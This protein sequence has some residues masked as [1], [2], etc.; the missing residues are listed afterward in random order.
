MDTGS[1]IRKKLF[2]SLGFVILVCVIQLYS[3]TT[4][5]FR[6]G[7]TGDPKPEEPQ[8]SD[9]IDPDFNTAGALGY[10]MLPTAGSSLV[11]VSESFAGVYTVYGEA[12]RYLSW[13]LKA[14]LIG[15]TTT[16]TVHTS[17]YQSA[18]KRLASAARCCV[19]VWKNDDSGKR[20]NTFIISPVSTAKKSFSGW[21]SEDIIT[22]VAGNAVQVEDGDRLV[23]EFEWDFSS[24]KTSAFT[25]KYGFNAAADPGYGYITCVN[26][27]LHFMPYIYSISPSS[28]TVN[29]T[30]S[31]KG[32]YFGDSPSA[33]DGIQLSNKWIDYDDPEVVN[34][35]DSEIVVTVP[36]G[37]VSGNVYVTRGGQNS[38]N[39]YFWILPTVSAASPNEAGQRASLWVTV[40]GKSFVYGCTASF[41]AGITVSSTS[42]VS[43]TEIKVQISISAVAAEG[44]R[45]ITVTNPDGTTNTL[46]DGFTVKYAPAVTSISPTERG[47]NAQNQDIVIN[48][49]YIMSG[50]TVYFM[51]G[52]NP[53]PDITINSYDYSGCGYFSGAILVVN[54]TVGPNADTL[55]NRAIKI[56]NPDLGWVQTDPA[57]IGLKINPKPT[58]ISINTGG[59]PSNALGQNASNITVSISGSNFQDTP[60]VQ[61]IPADGIGI[62]SVNFIDAGNIEIVVSV[63]SSAPTTWRDVKVIN[64]DQGNITQSSWFKINVKPTIYG[65]KDPSPPSRG[66]GCVNQIIVISGLNFSGSQVSFEGTGINV[67]W[68]NVDNSS[69]V[70]CQIDISSS[71]AT[72]WRYIKVTNQDFGYDTLLSAFEVTPA[73]KV[74]FIPSPYDVRGQGATNQNIPVRGSNF[75][76]G[77]TLEFIGGGFTINSYDY[78]SIPSTITVNV[79]ISLGAATGLRAIRATNPDA[80]TYVTHDVITVSTAPEVSSLSPNV[81]GQGASN[82]TIV[83]SGNYFQ[84]GCQVQF[85]QDPSGSPVDTT[86]TINNVTFNSPS[87][88]NI[89]ITIDPNAP[90]GGRYMKIVNPDEGNKVSANT[91]LNITNRPSFT[92]MSPDNRGQ[93]CVNEW[94]NVLGNYFQYGCNAWFSNPDITVSSTSYQAMD[95]IKIQISISSYAATGPCDLIVENPDKGISTFSGVF[96]VNK[97]PTV[98]GTIPNNLGQ[99]AVDQVVTITG[100]DFQSGCIADFG[101]GITVDWTSFISTTQIQAQIDIDPDAGT[102]ARNITVYNPDAGKHTG[103]GVFTVNPKPIINIV[104]P[105]KVGQGA[106]GWEITL[107]GANFDPNIQASDITISGGGVT[108]TTVTYVS[109]DKTQLKFKINVEATASTTTLRSI[110]VINPD[111]GRYTKENCFQITLKPVINSCSPNKVGQGA[112][113]VNINISGD[114]FQN[115]STVSFSQDSTGSPEDTTI[116]INNVTY[117]DPTSLT[118]NVT[119][120]STAPAGGRYITV[121]N[122]DGGRTTSATTL[123]TVS[124]R[125]NILNLSPNALGQG[126]SNIDVT[127]NGSNFQ[128]GCSVSFSPS[129]GIFIN[130]VNFVDALTVVVNLSVDATASTGTRSC[131]LTNPDYGSDTLNNALTINHKPVLDASPC[132]PNTRGA[133]AQSQDITITGQYFVAT[134]Q[135]EFSGGGITVNFVNFTDSTTIVA[136]IDIS[137][138]AALTTRNV[139]VT[140]PD[141]GWDT[142]YNVF[143]VAGNPVVTNATPDSR[144]QGAENQDILIQGNNF[145]E[146]CTVEFSNAG[147]TVNSVYRHGVSSLT[148]NISISPTAATG[149]CDITVINEDAGQGTGDDIFTINPKPGISGL[150]PDE[151]GQGAENM[152]ILINGSNFVNAPG[153]NV[154]FSTPGINVNSVEYMTDTQLRIFVTIST[155]VVSGVAYDVTV[156]NPDG[157]KNTL[158]NAFTV[159]P[160]PV[161]SATNPNNA[162]QGATDIQVFVTGSNFVY[163]ADVQFSGTGITVSS[164]AYQD[165]FTIKCT[166]S[167]SE[168]ATTGSRDVTVINPDNGKC[169]LVGGFTVNPG[170]VVTGCSPNSCGQ[171]AINQDIEIYG[172]NFQS[173]CSVIFTGGGITVNSVNFISAST[174]TA[175][176]TISEDAATGLRHIQVINPDYGKGTGV[177]LFTVNAKPVATSCSPASR[178]QGAQNQTVTITGSGFQVG[179]STS[180]VIFSGTG[181]TVESVNVIN[182]TTLEVVIDID[183]A[184]AVGDKQITI[185]NPDGGRSTSGNIFTVNP[186]PEITALDPDERGQGAASQEIIITGTDFQSG[187]TIDFGP[188]IN[189]DSTVFDSTTQVRA[190]I[191]IS[192]NAT[193]GAR[194]VTITNPDA[195]WYTFSG[196]FTVNP[197]PTI[198]SLSPDKGGQGATRIIDIYG[199]DF[200]AGCTA[201]FGDGITV[202]SVN[203]ID[204]THIVANI[205]IDVLAT[206]G[207]RDVTVTNPDQG[208]R[209]MANAFTVNPRPLVTDASPDVGQGAENFVVTITGSNF[210]EGISADFGA[211]ITVSTTVY[212]DPTTC[213]ATI[214]VAPTAATGP[215]DI[216]VTNLDGGEGTGSGVIT[217]NPKP[218]VSSCS[219]SERAQGLTGQVIDI[220][221]SGFVDGCQ[222][223]FD[224]VGISTTNISFQDASWVK[225]TIDI[226]TDAPLGA[227]DVIVINPDGGRGVGSGI[228][229]INPPPSLTSISPTEIGQGAQ[230]EII[231]VVGDNFQLGAIAS[232]SGAGI[233]VSSTAFVD[234][235]NLKVTLSISYT[236]LKTL[237]DIIITNPDGGSATLSNALLVG[238]PPTCSVSIPVDGG[239][240]NGSLVEFSG[241]ASTDTEKVYISIKDSTLLNKWYDEATGKFSSDVELWWEASYSTATNQW[242]YARPVS[243]DGVVYVVRAQAKAHNGGRNDPGTGNSFTYDI[244]KP[245]FGMVLP[246]PSAKINKANVT[247]TLSEEMKYPTVVIKFTAQT[248]NN[249][250][251]VGAE[252]TYTLTET[253]CGILT[254]QTKEVPGLITGNEYVLTLDGQDLAGNAASTVQRTGIIFDTTTALANVTQPGQPY[255]RELNTITG[256]AYDEYGVNRVW[257]AFEESGLYWDGSAWLTTETWFECSPSDGFWSG[258]SESWYYNIPVSSIPW[259]YGHTYK[260]HCK[261][262]DEA[263]NVGLGGYYQFTFDNVKPEGVIIE[264]EDN[265]NYNDSLTKIW[266]TASDVL[267][268]VKKVEIVIKRAAAGG[269]YWDGSSWDSSLVWLTCD[270]WSSSWTYTGCSFQD[271]E[272]HRLWLKITDNAD[273]VQTY[274]FTTDDDII[275]DVSYYVRFKYDITDPVTTVSYPPSDE[276]YNIYMQTFTGT[277]NDPNFGSGVYYVKIRIQRESDGQYWQDPGWAAGTADLPAVKVDATNWE[278]YLEPSYFSSF[279]IDGEIYRIY[280][281]AWDYAGNS[282][283]WSVLKSTFVYEIQAPTATITYPLDNGYVS[284]GGVVKGTAD[285]SPQP[286]GIVTKVQVRVRRDS[287]NKYWS[288][289]DSTWVVNETWNDTNLSPVGTY[290]YLTSPTWQTGIT[291]Y[292]SCKAQDK[293]ENWQT[294]ITT[295]SFVADFTAPTSCLLKPL[296]DKKYD[297]MSQIIGTADDPS[298]GELDKVILMIE[299]VTLGD[300]RKGYCWN[301]STWTSQNPY[302]LEATGTASWSYTID[303]STAT[304]WENNKYYRVTVHAVDK[305]GNEES[306]ETEG[307]NMNTFQYTAPPTRF[308][309]FASGGANFYSQ[310]TAGQSYTFELE[311]WNDDEGVRAQG[312][313]GTVQFSSDDSQA[314]FPSSYTFTTSD[315]GYHTFTDALIF[316]TA[317]YKYLK[318]EDGVSYA[319]T[320]IS[321]QVYTNVMPG[322]LSYFIV[323]GINTSHIAGTPQTVVVEAKDFYG[324]RKTNYAGIIHF[325]SNDLQATLPADYTFTSGYSGADNGIHTFVNGVVLKTANQGEGNPSTLWYVRVADGGK[326]G[327]QSGIKVFPA[328]IST[329]TVVMSTG[330]LTAGL[331]KSTVTVEAVDEFGNRCS[332]GTNLYSGTI[333]FTSSDSQAT[334]PGDYTFTTGPGGDNGYHVFYA[335]VVLRTAGWQW[336]KVEDISAGKWGYQTGIKVEPAMADHYEVTLPGG[337]TIV[338]GEKQDIKIRAID[339]YGNLDDDW[340]DLGREVTFTSDNLYFNFTGNY[341]WEPGIGEKT[342]SAWVW[343]NESSY[344]KNKRTGEYYSQITVQDTPSGISGTV[345]N[346]EVLAAEEDHLVV[347]GVNDPCIA[348]ANETVKVEVEDEY[349]NR[350]LVSTVTVHFTSD[351][352]SA[353]L[354][355]DYTFDS[356]TDQ[357]YHVFGNE[358]VFKTAGT[359]Y[360]KAEVVGSTQI[361]GQQSAIDVYPAQA[362]SFVVSCS[363]NQVIDVR[364]TVIVEAVDQFGNRCSIGPNAYDGEIQFNSDASLWDFNPSAY[365]FDTVTDQGIHTFSAPTYGMKISTGGTYYLEVIDVT[366]DG[367]GVD[368]ITGKKTGIFVTTLPESD[369]TYPEDNDYI[370]DL[371]PITIKGTCYDDVKVSKVEINIFQENTGTYWDETSGLF[372]SGTKLWWETTLFTSSWTYNGGASSD[373]FNLTSGM[374]Y[375]IEVRATDNGG[376]FEETPFASITFRYDI[377]A[378]E[379]YI[380]NASQDDHRNT[381]FQVSGTAEDM[382]SGFGSG[383]YSLRL[384][385]LKI[386]TDGTTQ[387][388]TGIG[389]GADTTLSLTAGTNWVYTT[390]PTWDSGF[391]YKI[392]ARHIDYAGNIE[393]WKETSFIYDTEAPDSYLCKPNQNFE[394]DI[395]LSKIWG[396]AIDNPTSPNWS[397]GVGNVQIRISSGTGTNI[398]W[399]GSS[400]VSMNP[401]D[402]WQDADIWTSS[403]TYTSGIP[404]CF[405]EGLTYVVNSRAIDKTTSDGTSNPNIEVSITTQTFIYDTTEP[406]SWMDMPADGQYYETMNNI[407]GTAADTSPG[408]VNY[409]QIKIKQVSGGSYTG[410]Y[411]DWSINDWSNSPGQVWS[412]PISL[413]GSDWN[414]NTSGVKWE[415]NATGIQYYTYFRAVDK[416]GN[417]EAEAYHS[418]YFKSPYPTTKV[419]NPSGLDISPNYYN[420]IAQIFGTADQYTSPNE[421]YIKISSAPTYGSSWDDDTKSWVIGE[422]WIQVDTPTGTFPDNNPWTCTISTEVWSNGVKYNVQSKG[423]GPAGWETPSEGVYFIIDRTPP[424]SEITNPADG[425]HANSINQ[426]SGTSWDISPGEIGGVEIYIQNPSG[427]YYQEGSWGSS[428]HWISCSP[429]D[430]SFDET[431]EGWYWDVDYPTEVWKTD[432]SYVIKVKAKDQVQPSPNEEISPYYTSNIVIDNVPPTSWLVYPDSYTY[433]YNSITKIWGT[434]ADTSPGI[435]SDIKLQ[436]LNKD[437]TQYWDGDAWN[438]NPQWLTNTDPDMSIYSSSWTYSGVNWISGYEYRITI[439]AVDKAR[440]IE[441]SSHTAIILYDNEEPSSNGTQ[442]SD[443][444]SY[445]FLSDIRGNAQDQTINL[446]VS[447]VKGVKV[448][449]KGLTLPNT[450]YW[451][452]VDWTGTEPTWFDAAYNKDTKLWI[453]DAGNPFDDAVPPSDG[454]YQVIIRAYD[455]AGNYQSV[456]TTV[457]FRWDLTPPSF[458]DVSPSTGDSI[459]TMDVSLRLG[460]KMQVG[461]TRVI[462]EAETGNNGEVSG[463]TETY[464]ILNSLQVQTTNQQT[465]PASQFLANLIDGNKY[466]LKIVGKDL[467]GN[468][469]DG[470]WFWQ[471]IIFDLTEPEA[472]FTYPYKYYH[473]SMTVI[474]GTAIDNPPVAGAEYSDI[475]HNEVKITRDPGGTPTYWDGSK[476]QSTPVWLVCSGTTTWNYTV[477]VTTAFEHNVEYRVDCRA[478][479]KAGNVQS[480]PN[481]YIFKIDTGI[482]QGEITYP[483]NGNYYNSMT[484]LQGTAV[485]DLSDIDTVRIQIKK[486]EAPIQYW[487][488]TGWN[489]DPQWISVTYDSVNDEWSYSSGPGGSDLLDGVSYEVRAKITDKAGNQ[490][491]SNLVTF[492]GDTENPQAGVSNISEGGYYNPSTLSDILGTANDSY[493]GIDKIEICIKRAPSPGY[494]WDGTGWLSGIDNIQWLTVTSTTSFSTWY[495]SGVAWEDGRLHYIW[496]KVYDKAGNMAKYGNFS[497]EGVGGDIDNNLNYHVS[498]TFDAS[499]PTSSVSFPLNETYY[500]VKYSTFSGTASDPSPGSDL[501]YIKIE[502]QRASDGK[503]WQDDSWGTEAPLPTSLVG[504]NW[505]YYMNTSYIDTFY[506][507]VNETYYIYTYAVD[508][509]GN[510]ETLQKKCTFYYDAVEPNSFITSHSNNYYRSSQVTKF[511]GSST[512]D[513]SGINKVEI[514]ISSGS[515]YWTGSSW[516]VNNTWKEVSYYVSGSTWAYPGE[517]GDI[518]PTWSDGGVYIIKVRGID[519]AGNIEST[520]DQIQI[521][522]DDSE[523]DSIVTSPENNGHYESLDTISGTA[524]DSL[525]GVQEV[526]VAIQEAFGDARYWDATNSQWVSNVVFNTTTYSGVTGVWSF[527]SSPVTFQDDKNYYVISKAYDKVG[528]EETATTQIKFSYHYPATELVLEK[529]DGSVFPSTVTAGVGVSVRVRAVDSTGDEAIWYQGTVH[530]E[531]TEN[532]GEAVLPPDY[533]FT[534][535]DAG[536]HTYSTQVILKKYGDWAITV[537]DTGGSPPNSDIVSVHVTWNQAAL[538]NVY[539]FPSPATAGV[540]YTFTVEARDGQYGTYGN[541]VK[542]YTGTVIFTSNDTKVS[543]GDGLPSNYTFTTNDQGVKNFTAQLR[544]V[545]TNWYIKVTDTVTAGGITG[546][547]SGIEVVPGALDHFTI[548]GLPDP[549]EAGTSTWCIVRVYDAFDNLKTDYAGTVEFLS[550]DSHPS[551]ILPANYKFTTGTGGDNGIHTFSGNYSTDTVKLCTKGYQT[552]TVRD[553]DAP[554]KSGNITVQVIAAEA[555]SFRVSMSTEVTAGVWQDITVEAID[556]FG[557]RQE[558]YDNEVVVFSSDNGLFESQGNGT[559]TN[560]YTVFNAWVRLNEASDPTSERFSVTVTDGDGYID[561]PSAITGSQT[562]IKVNPASATK[563]SLTGMPSS[564]VAGQGKLVTVKAKDDF[565]NTVYSWSG[566]ITFH[567]NETDPQATCNTEI[568]PS[569]QSLSG[570]G[571]FNIVYKTAG[572]NRELWVYATGL[573]SGSKTGIKVDPASADYLVVTLIGLSSQDAVTVNRALDIVVEAKDQFGNTAITY[574][575]TITFTSDASNYTLP[576][577]YHFD[578]TTD[579][580]IHT[581][582]GGCILKSTNTTTG[583]KV[584]AE[585]VND[586][587]IYGEKTG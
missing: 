227:C 423:Y 104:S 314:V 375:T 527:D 234:V 317:G 315:A 153:L 36:E 248:G 392:Q 389:W 270:I 515:Y 542:D 208:S 487:D 34:W 194:N 172:S 368:G 157:G 265:G 330:P 331:E 86:I 216:T 439:W 343:L 275:N 249:G 319:P 15:D 422:Y 205:T 276:Q 107:T 3:A 166:L 365:T 479:D 428:V 401:E 379:T 570:T 472:D 133:G 497:G 187:F 418:W 545:G 24:S 311:A 60:N 67:D 148:V 97:S 84:N 373:T 535:D 50:C 222:V 583:W 573:S 219:P 263:G 288:V 312:Y 191:T 126:A 100:L 553:V 260:V 28:Q 415:A 204:A 196:G 548:E 287:D 550:T 90:T 282:E 366:G 510:Q 69:Q 72:G 407:Y 16:W 462:Y 176:I 31:I 488:G 55:N 20:G 286:T 105:D 501:N 326:L 125:P 291:Y 76:N 296:D 372:N 42:F 64:P 195:G 468:Q 511:Y 471:H 420:Q 289:V 167:I 58:L 135:V 449:Y 413:T 154:Y 358:V 79:D 559:V 247:F 255:Y 577:D 540:D 131:T 380:V 33:G 71:A 149:A 62:N 552:L 111:K 184:T 264:P 244:T 516:T 579:Q 142:A 87:S 283:G 410:Y 587:G 353:T 491:I 229:T 391:L 569:T 89:N 526:R 364:F 272:Y 37:T 177:N 40:T 188:D 267:A 563:L 500:S 223:K 532:S 155:E 243:T 66:Q 39:Y 26:G 505:E 81:R 339:P 122:Q 409:V 9:T 77:C 350:V 201:D 280:S 98:L 285:D 367:K 464:A 141:Y 531:T 363:T 376:N 121:T 183:P 519:V 377:D 52:A 173:G 225:V 231:N 14:T 162:G 306:V 585:D 463:S 344:E 416:A 551:V 170:P 475:E 240:Y 241:S 490:Y 562:G 165:E 54:I 242:T 525:S 6:E 116:I 5:Y 49:D 193:T 13:P 481:N 400:W 465:I 541:I 150:N 181:I 496:M 523:P 228:F 292:A 357:G 197:R 130:S 322:D 384:K 159:N 451:N 546:Q 152:E 261:V 433:Y 565:D 127:I 438:I 103:Y 129:E 534:T 338:A 567:T 543:A 163:G 575:S 290:W 23:V 324:N 41:G 59:T 22:G 425:T 80:G 483:V 253:E 514:Q 47:Q 576:A 99:G 402:A 381:P 424:E 558:N 29:N 120:L 476:W 199:S 493:S 436:I 7:E 209:T 396:T 529:S 57:S 238:E 533:T 237:R 341:T 518:L 94:I 250:E 178:G 175:N 102:G 327:E 310:V 93:G 508:N 452:T 134:P 1:S 259:E 568:M 128:N 284:A 521:T 539:G 174:I 21:R 53:D 190:I 279:Y 443:G 469:D 119:I 502:I 450:G 109:G 114:G 536:I 185:V 325:T 73:P 266:G 458:Y 91:V 151:G 144:G 304:C 332:T 246:N 106:Q 12:R 561:N 329:F 140:N 277:Y 45:N 359:R 239:R 504:G 473:S 254:Q 498:F 211:G 75:Q 46:T 435:W 328:P 421:V 115:G 32:G 399:N 224:N 346:I 492:I 298:P 43:T 393:D 2:L 65:I 273:N 574:N 262:K 180:G 118:V 313:L 431:T 509:A 257:T 520:P 390:T 236:A 454:D 383:L 556:E 437:T 245:N 251:I 189:V 82:Q 68:T 303:E 164:A 146:N 517:T 440:N 320:I 161:V 566:I 226:S 252:H 202:N 432:G 351:D 35:T 349:G 117:N 414:I 485:D 581:W 427:E 495:Y 137:T 571:S 467:A 113:N 268:G 88:L 138:D 586:V 300:P 171:G 124:P 538:F 398:F 61:F 38:N 336:I 457:T 281:S 210:A 378:P 48:G 232:F 470:S 507:N 394:S 305:A 256:T 395:T 444:G 555:E 10:I 486:A 230:N 156:V 323:S 334:L 213:K 297:Q 456:Y 387:W 478:V 385:I 301:G 480:T 198:T 203:L 342:L 408:E 455:E 371:N 218:T 494:F 70:T 524:S 453:E 549:F 547:Q 269:L 92:S 459:N 302:W 360:I 11:E 200:Q 309:I 426:I 460:E 430:G 544:T 112:S 233:T 274:G 354:P 101:A 356:T 362:D 530:F 25:I 537:S 78:S 446:R 316:K 56:V 295:I 406:E 123:F 405:Q 168:S 308:R 374:D 160:S 557:N 382:P 307:R 412:D 321:T 484:N 110:T 44:A 461:P 386:L 397:A 63:S 337:L 169:T 235:N 220:T 434:G 158:S 299:N 403:W 528:N 474:S 429:S 445:N 564:V 108:V 278:W 132:T 499:T 318:V 139:T 182:D 419:T 369:I 206:V 217:V 352:P 572:T 179:I 466:T 335:T 388:W 560:G 513:F 582:T 96:T 30:I 258:S 554:A 442:P 333:H 136:N 441:T 145:R 147:I 584:R 417:S 51:L 347:S 271:G 578:S 221:G 294:S 512:D 355:A 370:N 143:T 19:Y 580:G 4:L 74:F 212:V 192:T 503:W 18:A 17:I 207:T 404:S 186:R 214:S 340:G 448:A 345:Y 215:R 506:Q 8:T 83:V 293:A 482:P 489:N 85:S 361:Y 27:D 348:G 95:S 447:T 522:I 477:S 411:W